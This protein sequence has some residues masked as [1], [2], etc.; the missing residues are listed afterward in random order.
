MQLLFTVEIVFL[1]PTIAI[2]SSLH[3]FILLSGEILAPIL[4]AIVCICIASLAFWRH[5]VALCALRFCKERRAADLSL[6]RT[7]WSISLRYWSNW[8]K[9]CQNAPITS[10]TCPCHLPS[11]LV[12]PFLPT[13]GRLLFTTLWPWCYYWELNT[14]DLLFHS[15]V[16]CVLQM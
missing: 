12:F 10:T 16:P 8:I 4:I 15:E 7:H 1:L 14:T 13:T 9:L 11:F 6:R 3:S 2:T 5:T